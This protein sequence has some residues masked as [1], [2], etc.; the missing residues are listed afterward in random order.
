MDEVQPIEPL[1]LVAPTREQISRLERELLALPQAEVP[2]EHTF[3]PGFYAR[4]ITLPPGTVLTGKVHSTEHIFIVSKG[5]ITLVTEEGRKRVQAPFQAVCKPGTKRAGYAHTE[6]VCTN[7]H[8]TPETDL[9]KLEAALIE[10][11]ALPAPE[12]VEALA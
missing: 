9:A 5:D 10:P 3:G 12:T 1:A 2:T 8:V 7:V 11:E 4:T 6:T